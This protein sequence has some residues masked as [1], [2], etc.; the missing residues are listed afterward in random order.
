M[1][2]ILQIRPQGPRW[3]TAD[4]F[5]FCVHHHDHYPRSDGAFG[6]AAS[7]A[8]RDVG[9]DFSGRDG[10]SM[11]HGDHVPGF[12]AHPHRGFET[13]TLVRRGLIDHSDSLGAIARFGEGDVQWVTAGSGL[14][15]SEMFPL[16]HADRDNPVELFQIWLNLPRSHKMADPN[17]TMLWADR[18][19]RAV[20]HDEQGRATELVLVAGALGE[21]RP[22]P[23]PPDSWAA[24]PGSDLAI[25]TLRLEAGARW[26]LPAAASDGLS[27]VLYVFNGAEADVAGQ[28]VQPTVGIHLRA[29]APV[30][31]QAGAS[32]CEFLLLQGRPI[33][34]PVA[35]YGPFVMNDQAGVMQAMQDYRRTQFGGWPF[36]SAAPVHGT[37]PRRFARYPDGRVERAG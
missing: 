25:W 21:L 23:P 33:N 10:W 14:V 7:L 17:F 2:P 12:P 8:G 22:P 9:Q 18:L 37:D 11:Y 26:T 35:Q 28:R 30:P 31:L 1:S 6:P 27:R 4:P 13:V 5:L 15:H 24:Q 3:E 20:F 19:P 29:D 34:E 32:G 16:L 36:E